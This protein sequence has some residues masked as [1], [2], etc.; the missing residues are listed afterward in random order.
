MQGK[1]V[2]RMAAALALVVVLMSGCLMTAVA[3]MGQLSNNSTS[4]QSDSEIRTV[5]VGFFRYPCYHEIQQDGSYSGY[6]VE[7]LTLLQRYADLN[8]EYVGYDKSWADMI[9]MLRK[10]EIDLVTSARK[11][12]GREEEFAFSE[13]IGTSW[14]QI[15]VRADDDRFE[16]EDYDA[17]NAK[18]IGQMLGNS[19]N[20]DLSQFAAEQGFVYRTKSYANEEELAQALQDGSVDAI[21]ATS[22]R[23]RFNERVVAE[24]AEEPFYVMMRKEDTALLAEVNYGIEQMNNN[25][26]GWQERLRENNY[27]A[28][29]TDQLTFNKR[30]KAYIEAVQSG[31]KTITVTGQADRDPYSFE[32]NGTMNGIIPEYFKELMEMAG[33]PYTVQIPADRN[34][35]EE[36][37]YS[38]TVDVVMDYKYAGGSV[39]T[40][41]HGIATDAYMQLMVARVVRR[42]FN[43]TIR[44]VAVVSGRQDIQIED[45]GAAD[46][47]Y[48]ECDSQE[49]AFQAVKDGRADAY[50]IDGYMAEKFVNQD[51]EGALIYNILSSPV[52][53]E[54]IYVQ[55]T[56]DHELVSILNKCIKADNSRRLNALVKKYTDYHAEQVTLTGFLKNN[57]LYT[58]TLLFAVMGFMAT[59]IF[60]SR[61]RKNA[62]ELADERLAYAKTLQQKNE[63]LEQSIKREE[64]ASRAKSEFLFNMSH[65][66]RTPMNAIL[67]FTQLAERNLDDPEK[68]TD[69][70]DK[71]NRSGDNL[72]DLIDNV[73]TM[74]K[75][76]SG[77][78]AVRE[79]VG[80]LR[81]LSRSILISFEGETNRRHQ[82]RKVEFHVTNYYVWMDAT[83]V[84]QIFMNVISNAIKYTPDGGTISA[85][86]T[87]YAVDREGYAGY[88]TIIE[89]TGIGIS[90]EFLPHIFDQF[91]RERNTTESG[92]QGTGLGMAI[93]KK[94]VDQLGGT[95]RI[96]SELG[97]GTRVIVRLE[98]RVAENAELP[99]KTDKPAEEEVR[100]K[101]ILL[102]EDN[103]L[104]AEIAIELLKMSGCEVDR[105]ENGKVCVEKLTQAGAGRY[106]VVLM[107]IQM[108]VMNGYEATRQ[109]RE[110]DD[111]ALRLIPII[112]MTANAFE[113]D[114][115]KALDAGMNGFVAKPIDLKRLKETL[116]GLQSKNDSGMIRENET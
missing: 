21:I 46:A 99:A 107:D 45:Q 93:V 114:K 62:Q 38:G 70:L 30:E 47:E 27:A 57:P 65:D 104:N 53:N 22:A 23:K 43:G 94:N 34:Q 40:C 84:R 15:C 75:I 87:E 32:E 19:R 41:Q 80:D 36:W 95:V 1:R 97:K 64:A 26:G 16:E 73:L 116:A 35:L 79:S 8:Y 61:N 49:D 112:A 13:P 59:I 92:I 74:S 71:I 115:K 44:T 12:P 77:A 109:I 6:G 82:T 85:T 111:P 113:E 52:Y 42:N 10:G 4:Q 90:S 11:T 17:L 63:E 60:I 101:R 88:E 48:L 24:F 67:G 76:E 31:E 81:E 58:V 3:D 100:G 54:C 68:L 108:P 55:S 69:Y 72:L 110:S 102:A 28:S 14:A 91:E 56:M 86:T 96:E 25:E 103:D 9:R 51:T 2:W 89:D 33:L 7:F 50:Y 66:I 37:V 18:T 105:A 78:S 106:D 98:F 83:K 39:P 29:I 20:Y 5:R